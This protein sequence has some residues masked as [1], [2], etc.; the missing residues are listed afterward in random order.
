MKK[1]IIIFISLIVVVA[2]MGLVLV[3]M[4]TDE[5]IVTFTEDEIKFKEEYET[6]NGTNYKESILLKTINIDSD[7]NVKYVNDNEILDL[8]KNGTNVIYFGWAE[9][10]WCRTIIPV[11]IETLKENE[12]ETLYYYDFK[13]LRLAYEENSDSK[14]VELYESILEIIGEDIESVFDEESERSGEKKILAP[15]VVFVKNG[16]YIGSHI[17]SVDSQLKS[18]DELTESQIIELKGYYNKYINQINMD[19]CYEEGC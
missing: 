9:C 13:S 18:S 15:T 6:L 8:L 4:K 17:K 14:K 10:N 5:P 16:K 1:R 2:V 7:N 12:I 11:L 3:F 19:V